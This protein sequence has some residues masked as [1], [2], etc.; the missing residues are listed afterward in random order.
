MSLSIFEI[1]FPSILDKWVIEYSV[2]LNECTIFVKVRNATPKMQKK[3]IVA[4]VMADRV[5][6]KIDN[7]KI[8]KKVQIIPEKANPENNNVV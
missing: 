5:V 7:N 4:I 3:I 8:R 1:S 2:L 6:P